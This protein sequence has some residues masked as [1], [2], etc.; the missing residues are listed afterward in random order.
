MR[1]IVVYILAVCTL[2][3]SVSYAQTITAD[4]Y[5]VA[6]ILKITRDTPLVVIDDAVEKIGAINKLDSHNIFKFDILRPSDTSSYRDQA[7]GRSIVI[8]KTWGAQVKSYQAKLSAFSPDYKKY[9]Q[10]RKTGDKGVMYIISNSKKG[11]YVIYGG[12]LDTTLQLMRMKSS[13]IKSVTA[14]LLPGTKDVQV[15]EVVIVLE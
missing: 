3:I 11:S 9:I 6:R 10:E 8:V 5:T 2:L 14:N 12:T 7:K 13:E 1:R 4:Q 15:S